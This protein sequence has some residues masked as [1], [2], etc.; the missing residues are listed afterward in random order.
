ME[1]FQQEQLRSLNE[2]E[3]AVYNYVSGH[4][5]EVV[6]MNIR[7]LSAATGVSTTTILRFCSKTGCDG[8]KDFKYRLSKALEKQKEPKLYFPSILPAIQYLEHMRDN[9]EFETQADVCTDLCMQARQVLFVGIGTSG[10][11]G[12]YGA[13]LLSGVGIMAFAVTD[14]Y[15]SLEMN[16]A[17]MKDTVVI[18]LSVSGETPQVIS[19]VDEF[20]KRQAKVISITNT[21]QC[22]IAK[23]SEINFPYYMPVAY[24]CQENRSVNLTTQIPVLHLLETLMYKI[25]L[26]KQT[27]CGS[28]QDIRTKKR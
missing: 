5:Y 16:R 4:I 20:R 7:E 8:Y 19:L 13:R 26:I 15:Y 9:H 6:K 1:L 10:K 27:D 14:P 2:G 23:M 18:V 12:E 24:V 17:N 21:N 28:K 25:Y 22:T 11:L 3:F